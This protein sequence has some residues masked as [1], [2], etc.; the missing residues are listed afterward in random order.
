MRPSRYASRVVRLFREA[1]RSLMKTIPKLAVYLALLTLPSLASAQEP[2]RVTGRVTDGAGAPIASA[3]VFIQSLNVSVLSTQDGS[4]T[5]IVPASRITAG[6]EVQITAQTI[7]YQAGNATITLRPGETV[8]RDFQLGLDVL[9]LEGI[10][11]TGQG[12]TR[13]RTQLGSVVN[14]VTSEEIQQSREPNIVSALAGKA[15]GVVVTSSSGDPGAGA[16]IQI[17]GAASVVGGTQPLFIVDGTPIDNTT[18]N[19]GTSASISSSNLNNQNQVQGVAASNRGVDLNPN[20]IETIDILKGAA[21]TAIYGSRA[22]NGVVIIT[23]KSGRPGATRASFS[24]SL[25][26]DK[27]TSTQPLQRQYGQGFDLTAV[28]ETGVDPGV[29]SWGAPIATGTP[30][31]DHANE[32]YDTGSR[33]ENNLTLSGGSDRTTYYLSLGWLSQD[34]VIVGPQDFERKSVRLKGTQKLRDDLTIGGNFAYTDSN[35]DF[36]QRGS[37]ISG[38]QLGALRTPPEFN[39]LPYLDPTTGL[40]RSYRNPNPTSATTTRGYDN[41]FWVA[42]ELSNTASVGRSFGNVSLD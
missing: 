2:A 21:A 10:V 15:P 4:Y 12:M 34:G 9:K 32:V 28:G 17:R 8:T 6:R 5:L 33:V 29:V 40:H 27:V 30:T 38:I 16:Y 41:P 39:N 7:G 42:N 22:A 18:V 35:G 13:S 23:T 3:S 20:D 14:T 24:S 37:N 1:E 26:F 19:I 36:V 25:G 31:Y 11:A